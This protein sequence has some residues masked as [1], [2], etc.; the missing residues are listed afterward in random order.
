MEQWTVK[1]VA[2]ILQPCSEENTISPDADAMKA[3]SRMNRN[4]VSRLMVTENGEL[5]GILSLKDLLDFLSLKVE[6]EE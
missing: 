6:L 1:T 5:R 4:K 2:D 3:L